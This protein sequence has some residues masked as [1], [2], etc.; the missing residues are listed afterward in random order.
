MTSLWLIRHGE[1]DWN[2]SGRF[3]GHTDVALNEVGRRQAHRLAKR[4]E[5]DHR[6]HRFAGVFSSDLSRASETAKAA[7]QRLRLEVELREG[8]RERNYGVLSALTPAQMEAQHPEIYARWH[9]R[10]PEYVVPGG[11]SLRQ[12]S[13]RVLQEL[14]EIARRHP[15]DQVLIVAH[16]GVLDCAWRAA[17]QMPLDAKRGHPLRNASINRVRVDEAGTLSVE[18]WGDVEHLE[19]GAI[20]EL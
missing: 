1:T 11:E 8:L 13:E 5:G 6:Q 10:D 2:T 17:T 4:L 12:F 15:G 19:N 3:Q 18:A 20:D 14:R 7:A 9:T 16:G